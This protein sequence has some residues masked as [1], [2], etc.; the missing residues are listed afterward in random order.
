[1]SLAARDLSFR[2]PDASRWALRSVDLEA[3]D[4]Q[5]TCLVGATG[6]GKSTL[7]RAM[8][9]LVAPTSGE[10]LVDGQATWERRG[11][12]GRARRRRDLP[13]HV[14]YVMQRPERQLFAETVEKDVAFGP[15]N[16]GLS[17]KE[18]AAAAGRALDLLGI[19][20]LAKR[21]PFEL[22]GGQQRLAAIAGVLAM[23]PA[24]LVLDEPMA[25]LDPEGRA[26]VRDAVARLSCGSGAVLLVTHDMDDAASLASGIF[27]M[28]EGSVALSGTPD[29]VFSQAEKLA[30]LGL[31]L[32]SALAFAHRLKDGHG[33]DLGEPVTLDTLAR[34]IALRSSSRKGA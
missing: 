26:I 15:V 13:R 10:A 6:S 25:A 11:P 17:E 28:D 24:N 20:P 27:V 8:A 4:G 23:G 16:L 29:E 9:G 32:P 30:R 33:I 2:Y 31:G 14:G 3:P 19:A 21:S 5:V 34:A 7:L 1:M 18:A 22:S 12:F